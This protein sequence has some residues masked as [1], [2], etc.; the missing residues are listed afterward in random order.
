MIDLAIPMY[1]DWLRFVFDHPVAGPSAEPWFA[2]DAGGIT[3]SNPTTLLSHFTNFCARI[4]DVAVVRF[5]RGQIDEGLQLLLSGGYGSLGQYLSV[6]EITLGIR[7]ECVQAMMVPFR[8]LVARLEPPI[9]NGF[10]MWWHQILRDA[11]WHRPG[12]EDAENKALRDDV[13]TTL[14]AILA[15]ES[16]AC[17]A[18]AL[19]GL[20]HLWHPRRA[21]VVSAWIDIHGDSIQAEALDPSW[22]LQCRDGSVM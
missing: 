17:H 4:S 5:S 3:A 10:Y 7:R 19:H 1:E 2:D 16:A 8:D 14:E 6:H 12:G 9:E 13:L 21:G 18:C 22:L 11:G 15:I 20:G